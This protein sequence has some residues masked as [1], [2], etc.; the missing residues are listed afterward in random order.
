RPRL[1]HSQ[2]SLDLLN[3]LLSEH[4]PMLARF[5]D[6][7][8]SSAAPHLA[9]S[10]GIILVSDVGLDCE[11]WKLIR[12]HPHLPIASGRPVRTDLL[13]SPFFVPWTERT[14]LD[15]VLPIGWRLPAE[16]VRSPRS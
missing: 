15:R 1:N 5:N 8:V 13:W 7:L 2:N 12:N 16:L 3:G 4:F 6:D 9:K 10:I 14:F 11:G